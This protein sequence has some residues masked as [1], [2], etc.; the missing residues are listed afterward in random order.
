MVSFSQSILL[1]FHFCI[2]LSQLS[3]LVWKLAEEISLE[4]APKG[5]PSFGPPANN[6][7]STAKK[8]RFR[9]NWNLMRT[10]YHWSLILR[11]FSVVLNS[12]K[13]DTNGFFK[14]L[15]LSSH[16]LI[17]ATSCPKIKV[18]CMRS[19]GILFLYFYN[20]LFWLRLLISQRRNID[21]IK[22]SCPLA[23]L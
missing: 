1:L 8:S 17:F 15:L 2:F 12:A 18:W 6:N 4:S 14:V 11:R 9:P 10:I 19:N 16:L 21:Q 5:F 20:D 13:C 3:E 22:P 23:W 7:K